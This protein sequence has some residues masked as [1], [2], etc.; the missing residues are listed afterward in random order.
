[1]YSVA[2]SA[3]LLKVLNFSR[4]E[5]GKPPS[6]ANKLKVLTSLGEMHRRNAEALSQAMKTRRPSQAEGPHLPGPGEPHDPGYPCPKEANQTSTWLRPQEKKNTNICSS[7][8]F[9]L[10]PTREN[11]KNNKHILKQI[12]ANPL[13]R[14]KPQK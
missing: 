4:V 6:L 13:K 9:L 10:R 3:P 2:T 1:M 7:D 14:S 8:E 11:N 5:Y 12:E